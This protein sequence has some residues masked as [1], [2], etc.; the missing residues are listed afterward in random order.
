MSTTTENTWPKQVRLPGQAAAPDGPVDMQIMYVMH[1]AFRRDLARFAVAARHTP[2]EDSTTWRLL[3][4]RWALFAEIL[5]MHHSGEDAGLWPWLLEHGTPADRSTLQAMEAEHAEIDPLLAACA[6]GFERV[7]GHGDEDA[8]AALT[9]R[10]VAT[11][12]SLARHLAH[13]ETDAIAILQR[14]MTPEEWLALDEEFFKSELTPRRVV[15]LVPWAAYGLPRDVLDRVF[16]ESGLGFRLV[17][18]ATRR[19][20]ARREARTFRYV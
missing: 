20:F 6:E 11:R 2:A 13:E 14:L 16:A 9:V 12:D 8:R 4:S 1:H 3:A 7:A 10:L 17:W 15:S 18:L 19:R 5:H